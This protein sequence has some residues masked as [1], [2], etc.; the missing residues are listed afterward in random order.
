[1]RV[2]GARLQV[3][4]KKLAKLLYKGQRSNGNNGASRMMKVFDMYG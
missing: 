3:T 1:M 4:T 2:A